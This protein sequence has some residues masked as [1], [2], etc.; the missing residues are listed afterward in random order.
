[1]QGKQK[2]VD[3]KSAKKNIVGLSP[4][5]GHGQEIRVSALPEVFRF[6]QSAGRNL[7]QTEPYPL[8]AHQSVSENGSKN[9]LRKDISDHYPREMLKFG[10]YGIVSFSTI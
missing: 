10:R 7:S 1:V 9:L 3:L 5:N 2:L 4:E 8:H 6:A